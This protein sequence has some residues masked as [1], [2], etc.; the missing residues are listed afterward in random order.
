MTAH[1][2]QSTNPG[3]PYFCPSYARLD[4]VTGA[5]VHLA[6][7]LF[8]IYAETVRSGVPVKTGKEKSVIPT[9]TNNFLV[10]CVDLH[11]SYLSHGANV[12][13]CAQKICPSSH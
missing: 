2:I 3:G 8:A 7:N 6:T 9:H 12:C 5:L 13:P 1:P 4:L 10:E 11:S